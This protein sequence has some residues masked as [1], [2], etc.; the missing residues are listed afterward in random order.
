M[1]LL[2]LPGL[3][4]ITTL[5]SL[6]STDEETEAQRGN[7]Y[8]RLCRELVAELDLPAPEV[9]ISPLTTLPHKNGEC[10]RENCQPRSRDSA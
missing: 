8:P 9:C 7:I 6:C 2:Y 5:C 10:R 1:L 4:L 3:F